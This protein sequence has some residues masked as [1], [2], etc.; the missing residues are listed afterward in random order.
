M[1]WQV[2][3]WLGCA[4]VGW[5]QETAAPAADEADATGFEDAAE[6]VIHAEAPAASDGHARA[7]VDGEA[8][9][10]SAGAD[11]AETLAGVP[12]VTAQRGTADTSKPMVR[13]LTERRLLLLVDGVRHEG[14]AWGVD[15]APEIDPTAAGEIAV[16]RGAAAS[17]YGPDAL[18][19][20]ILLTP[21][22]LRTTLGVGGMARASWSSNGSRG[23]L[24][25]RLDVVPAKAS[26][27]T[28]RME[29]NGSVGR[30]LVAPDYVLGNT[31]SRTG[32]LGV[33]AGFRF[34]PGTL[35]VGWRRYALGAGVFF[36]QRAATPEALADA[37]SADLPL[38]A[39]SWRST[40]RFERPSQ[41]VDHDVVTAHL[42]VAGGWGRFEALYAFQNNNRREYDTVRDAVTGPQYHFVRRAQSLDAR[43]THPALRWGVADVE[44]GVGLQVRFSEHLYSGLPLL[45]NDRGAG[46]G[47][48]AWE[49]LRLP[50]G[51]VSLSLRVD[52]VGR[53][54][55][56][57]P[58][59]LARYERRGVL[60]AASC[61]PID[62]R[63]A[64]DRS[65]TVASAS[66]GGVAHLLRE[67]L[68]LRMDLSTG[69]RV[70]SV[71]ELYLLGTAPTLPIFVV[72]DPTLGAER[73]IGGSMTLSGAHR[74]VTG[75]VSGFGQ[76][77]LDWIQALPSRN[78][79]G[80]L[81]VDVTVRGAFPTF[82]T[83]ARDVRVYGVDGAASVAPDAPLGLDVQAALVRIEA[84][85]APGQ[86]V[87]T[88]PDRGTATLWGRP[89][90]RGVLADVALGL[91][92]QWVGRSRVPAAEDLAPPTSAYGLLGASARVRLQLEDRALQL[93]VDASNL[94]DARYRDA[95]SLLRYY[96]DEPGRDVRV[97]LAL[98]L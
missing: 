68:D 13:G 50:R 78:A 72:P 27:L 40:Y 75:E 4:R 79:A 97:W 44:G 56:F 10:S 46:V 47:A 93:G 18:G 1:R 12:G 69:A 60:D 52:H 5:A 96:G 7:V 15:H 30:A 80:D 53:S 71:D 20:V 61:R 66:V 49:R 59:D 74:W 77:V 25:A 29:A 43:W 63:V 55:F 92:G 48:F 85:G 58:Q 35:R 45:P 84:L 65:W 19:G 22:A 73:S 8:I 70:P 37:V 26:W 28:L 86:V 34:A 31:A 76:V 89:P 16:V 24:A 9:A 94:L 17:W 41:A 62:A 95:T 88:P 83:L 54:A 38:G 33:S 42:D 2:V 32:N 90:G 39:E 36:G 98:D 82:A 81:E 11:L 87:G 21:P 64:C 14:Q 51:D 23:F 6:I 67:G 3:A 57:L 91:R